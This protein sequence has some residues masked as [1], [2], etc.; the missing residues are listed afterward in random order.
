M[1][2]EFWKQQSLS[3]KVVWLFLFTLVFRATF[4]LSIGLIDDEAFHWSWTKPLQLSY[5]DHPGMIAWLESLTTSLFGDTVL[6]VR[7]PG[8]LCY[9]GTV[10][11][12]YKLTRDLFDQ[13]AAIF[14][15]FILLWSPFWGFGGY[16][17]SP[18]PPFM[19]CWVAAAYVFWQGAREDDQRWS[20]KKTWLWLGVLMGL[21]L[22]SKFI[23][24]LLAPGFG[25]Y[26]LASPSRRR[27]LLTPWPW[28]GFL[29]ATVITTPVF[30]W[31]I[32]Y[33]W[34]G[35]KYQFHDRH[36]GFSFSMTRWLTYFAAQILFTTPF[37]YVMIVLAFITSAVK[38]K[39]ARWRFLFFLT[40][41]SIAI[42]YPQPFFADYK[43]HWVGAAY[44]LL[45]MGAGAI[46]SQGLVWGKRQVIK[47]RSKVFTRGILAF[48]I[49]L[50]LICY[51]PFAYPWIPKVYKF[52][53][54]N[55]HWETKFDPSNEFTGWEELGRYVNRR[56]REIHA[57][58]GRKPF[59]AA[60][61]YETT[62]QT[63]WGVKQKV[64]MLS[65]T[66]SHYTVIQSPEEMNNLKGEDA[67][68]VSTEKYEANP[69]EWAAWDGG[70]EKEELKTFRQGVHAR[71]FFIYYCKGFQKIIN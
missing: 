33:D 18:E 65:T 41:P 71:T 46:W 2:R 40:L 7:L 58:S 3:Q 42:F 61:R 45:L 34:P 44:T 10:I 63:F 38:I 26:L 25:L 36:A 20:T 37:L 28:V 30:M 1:I 12:L 51:T 70:C 49:P 52:I 59:I 69:V 13:W 8:F 16:V 21:G 66:R 32:A 60:H 11:L 6:G 29:I 54:P 39:E 47:A 27:D 22:N 64:Y 50:A 67:I 23:I 19:L 17:A 31:N 68:F 4:A 43:P 15:G 9:V 14:V 35:F 48:F 55:G 24:A 56:Q 5:Y 62:A 57:E 53:N